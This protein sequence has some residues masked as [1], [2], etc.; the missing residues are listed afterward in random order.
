[1]GKKLVWRWELG[2]VTLNRVIRKPP[3]DGDKSP[4]RDV[5]ANL[6]LEAGVE[7]GV[8]LGA[9]AEVP[10]EVWVRCLGPWCHLKDFWVRQKATKGLRLEERHDLCGPSN[11]YPGFCIEN[12]LQWG[13]SGSRELWVWNKIVFSNF[14]SLL[15]HIF[16]FI[17]RS[18]RSLLDI[19]FLTVLHN[20][21][22]PYPTTF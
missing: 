14:L 11:V 5:T 22:T 8:G 3:A 4:W 12:S 17:L 13:R 2:A 20:T 9:V 10:D 7:L 18:L 1:M 19:F 15:F 16:F 21:F 6:S